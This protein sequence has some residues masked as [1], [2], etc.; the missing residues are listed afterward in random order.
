[1]IKLY[2]WGRINFSNSL[3]MA[4]EQL[5]L[6]HQQS[7]LH[8]LSLK[9]YHSI[10]S[11]ISML[12]STTIAI[13]ERMSNMPT[14]PEFG[15][16]PTTLQ[17]SIIQTKRAIL[18]PEGQC[19]SQLACWSTVSVK[20]CAKRET[21]RENLH[22]LSAFTSNNITSLLSIERVIL[23]MWHFV[24]TAGWE[25]WR[26]KTMTTMSW[27]KLLHNNTSRKLPSSRRS[28][29][30]PDSKLAL[31]ASTRWTPR[32]LPLKTISNCVRDVIELWLEKI[33]FSPDTISSAKPARPTLVT[34]AET[35]CSRLSHQLNSEIIKDYNI[36]SLK[37][38]QINII[39]ILLTI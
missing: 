21:K 22:A 34:T 13:S 30:L 31:K 10:S 7:C 36:E 12:Q 26:K 9:I 24:R 37:H 27:D 16:N 6:V 2:R 25:R 18:D 1:M 17:V 11:T 8:K 32:L 15:P 4:R 23:S 33:S 20:C 35:T 38:H 29:T 3:R 19:T 14:M 5:V 39:I 28:T